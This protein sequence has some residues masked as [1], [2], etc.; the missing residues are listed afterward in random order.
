MKKFFLLLAFW[1]GF[2]ALAQPIVPTTAYTRYWLLATNAQDGVKRLGFECDTIAQM[3][4]LPISVATNQTISGPTNVWVNGY[5][6]PGDGGGGQ[7]WAQSEILP[8]TTNMGTLF[9]STVNTNYLWHRLYSGPLNV[10]WFGAKAIGT[11]DSGAVTNAYSVLSG[12]FGGIAS[13]TLYF[14]NGHYSVNLVFTN[15]NGL[16]LSGD[17]GSLVGANGTV[18]SPYDKTKSVLQFGND[19]GPMSDIALKGISF[20][21]GT[22]DAASALV[23]GGGVSKINISDCSFVG[24]T[25]S[26]SVWGGTNFATEFVWIQNGQIQHDVTKDFGSNSIACKLS[27]PSS[28]GYLTEVKFNNFGIRDYKVGGGSGFLVEAC[29]ASFAGENWYIDGYNNHCV[30]LVS[31]GSGMGGLG[32]S[33]SV[34]SAHSS[35][36][37]VQTDVLPGLNALSL[38]IAGSVQIDGK[39]K[40]GNGSLSGQN[41]STHFYGYY[42]NILNG[43]IVNQLR[44]WDQA[45]TSFQ[46][47]NGSNYVQVL[48]GVMNPT[49][50]S[51]FKVNAP[52]AQLINPSYGQIISGNSLL[53]IAS[54]TGL[55]FQTNSTDCFSISETTGE[56]IFRAD[57]TIANADQ[58]LN[59]PGSSYIRVR[60]SDSKMSMVSGSGALSLETPQSVQIYAN[61]GYQMNVGSSGTYIGGNVAAT[62]P[63]QVPNL[64][65]YANNAAALAGGLTA[66]AFYRTGADPDPVCVVH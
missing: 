43:G 48:N 47:G 30:N 38:F 49:A 16:I 2:V 62:S 24:F 11:D 42:P 61:G 15:G 19:V 36:T 5:Y 57:A 64:P 17:G 56:A 54:G 45:D 18:L 34:D 46:Y 32:G 12:N 28:G 27:Y 3:V 10:K 52:I 41:G 23:I 26:I 40:W 9:R 58:K 13:G 1:F 8:A 33:G 39:I 29:G 51:T 59:F 20:N 25:N 55:R 53:T 65:I 21:E 6:T 35:D 22:Y 63:L 14:P 66:G 44:F 50:A 37:L 7:F 60:S 31:V 4:A